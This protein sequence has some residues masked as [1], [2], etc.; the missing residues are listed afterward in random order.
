MTDFDATVVGAGPNGLAAAVEMA[1]SGRKVLV[2]EA[3]ARPGGGARTEELTIPGFRHDIC[4]A[5]HPTGL[6][7]PFF[8]A[9][10]L[11]VDWIQPP[12]PF[13][14]PLDGGRV[15]AMY[16]SVEETA[17]NLGDDRARYQRLMG[18]LADSLSELVEVALSPM[19]L[20]PPH[21]TKFARLAVVGGLP[22]GMVA[23]RFHTEEARGLFAGLAAHAI[24]PFNALATTGVG[25]FLGVIGH[26]MGWPLARGG[27]EAITDALAERLISLGGS[28]ETDR[29]VTSVADLPGTTHLL[30]VMP[31]AARTIGADRIS[32]RAARRL[33][34]WKPGPGVFKVDWAL[35]GPVPWADPLSAQAGTVH[36]G[37]SLEEIEA[38]ERTVF[39]GG[40]P[41]K[42]FVL[43]AQQSPF[44]S[45]RAP[46]GRHTL[47]GYCHV[48]NGSTVDMTGPIEDQIERFAPG[49]RERVIGR[50]T[51]NSVQ[52][53]AHN[54]NLVGGDI[55][56]GQF[57][58]R[59]VLQF[60]A[61][62]PYDLGGGVF[63]CSSAT[64]PG[65]GVH[66]MSGY[67]AARAALSQI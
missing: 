42:P 34:R 62:R 43:V 27:S 21:K 64:P 60:G 49:F 17:A 38:A 4:S 61:R 47:W 52:Y 19:S 22:A 56:G 11:D 14:H 1:R 37:G 58:I 59:K 10:G 5:I 12:I 31:P 40:H 16:R 45:S 2:V 57:G 24:A 9:I 67:H 23:R 35:D 18:P 48:P 63:L 55:G 32:P 29:T 25:L 54:A 26:V 41:E 28:I 66:G 15:A 8:A 51:R 33:S 44:D 39:R 36:V 20:N 50:A 46:Q 13:T 30:D 65:A 3:A 53:Q 6:A 7:S